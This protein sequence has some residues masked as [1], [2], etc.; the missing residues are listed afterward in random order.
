MYKGLISIM[1]AN[2][3]LKRDCQGFLRHI[4]EFN[5]DINNV[6]IERV[7]TCVLIKLAMTTF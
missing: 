3:F 7:L 4:R 1:H 2:K 6:N 5:S